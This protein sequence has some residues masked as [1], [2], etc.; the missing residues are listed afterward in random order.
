MVKGHKNSQMF[1][2]DVVIKHGREKTA[3]ITMTIAD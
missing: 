1:A 3:L 2:V